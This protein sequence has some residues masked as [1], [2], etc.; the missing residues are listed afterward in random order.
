MSLSLVSINVVKPGLLTTIQDGGR[1]GSQKYGVVKG[2]AMDSFAMQTANLL[3]Q[4]DRNA[5]VL[6]MTL[7]GPVLE[8]EEDTWIAV[9]GADLTALVQ[10]KP[11]PLWRPVHVKAGTVLEFKQPNM[12]CRAY[13]AIAGG[14]AADDVLGSTG[15]YLRAGFGGLQGRVLQAHDRLHSRTDKN[16]IGRGRLKRMHRFAAGVEAP[17]WHISPS[18]FPSYS[19]YPHIRVIAGREFE[20]F[21]STSQ[22]GIFEQSYKVSNQSDRMGY[23]L[24]GEALKMKKPTEL[25][26]EAV[27]AGTIQVPPNG[28]PIVLMADSQTTGGYPRIGQ[29]ALVDLPVLAQLRPG[30]TIQFVEITLEQ[31]Q[32]LWLEREKN[33]NQL[34]LGIKSKWLQL[35]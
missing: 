27:T 35:A 11:L 12:G 31:S 7:Q 1:W 25:L 15:T 14:F 16:R 32:A 33:V 26:S 13:L 3:L 4:N 5:P 30:N 28:Q 18:I 24:E 9:C 6:E 8:F 2:G 34:Q 21:T 22:K 23:R 10:E 20:Q 19:L 29:I 17:H